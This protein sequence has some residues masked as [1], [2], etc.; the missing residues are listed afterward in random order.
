M[1]ISQTLLHEFQSYFDREFLKGQ[2]LMSKGHNDF[3]VLMG[4]HKAFEI[5]CYGLMSASRQALG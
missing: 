3:L 2:S 5:C 1:V 4:P